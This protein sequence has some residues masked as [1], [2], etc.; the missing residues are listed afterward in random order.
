MELPL[1]VSPQFPNFSRILIPLG[2]GIGQEESSRNRTAWPLTGGSVIFN[3]SHESTFVWVNLGMGDVVTSFNV[4]LV[5]VYNSSGVGLTC[6]P[7]PGRAAIEGLNI[8]D[9]MTASVQ[10]ITSG[11]SGASLFNVS[12]RY[13]ELAFPDS[14]RL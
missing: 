2:A 1:Y 5:P 3:S 14:N 11:G 13:F 10:V 9:G 6:L 12:P 7:N 4:S 8:T